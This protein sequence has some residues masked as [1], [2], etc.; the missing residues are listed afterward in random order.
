MQPG[1]MLINTGNANAGTG[2]DGLS[3]ARSTCVTLAAA[4]GLVAG[5]NPAVFDRRD[6]GVLAD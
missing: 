5:A 3:R 6:H 4:L 1:A 2:E